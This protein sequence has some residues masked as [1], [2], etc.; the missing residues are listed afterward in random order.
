[1]SYSER[2]AKKPKLAQPLLKHFFPA[3]T[4]L[5]SPDCYPDSQSAE[6]LNQFFTLSQP[7]S[8]EPQHITLQP[9]IQVGQDF[10]PY[11]VA[12]E[13]TALAIRSLIR[14]GLPKFHGYV[15]MKVWICAGVLFVSGV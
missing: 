7:E 6:G 4:S 1:M 14:L 15:T 5:T 10:N 8:A 13:H 12:K 9:P 2:S 3:Q 11:L